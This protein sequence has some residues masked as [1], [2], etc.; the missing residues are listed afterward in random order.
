MIADA[1]LY[2]VASDD[3]LV[4]GVLSSRVH[5]EWSSARGGRM[6][7]GDDPRYQS[8]SCFAPFPFPAANEAQVA[9]IRALAETIDAHRWARRELHPRLALTAIYDVIETM[10]A[11]TALS[12]EH[13]DTERDGDVST[14]ARLHDALD[15]AVLDAY[16]WPRA[17]DREEMLARLVA[18]NRERADEERRGIVRAW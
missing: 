15:D 8:G 11:G 16:G 13:R 3:A 12:R 6:G 17:I 4:L 9:S 1:S 7:R 18:L 10:R 14:L 5:V 2:V